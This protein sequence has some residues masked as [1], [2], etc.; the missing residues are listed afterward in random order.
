MN[1]GES[2]TGVYAVLWKCRDGRT[3]LYFDSAAGVTSV[4][5]AEAER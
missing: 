2:T 1:F 5:R 3:A 4:A